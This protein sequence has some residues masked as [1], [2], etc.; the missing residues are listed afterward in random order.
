MH[1]TEIE[2]AYAA[3]QLSGFS[4]FYRLLA[5]PDWFMPVMTDEQ[6]RP[7]SATLTDPNGK[8]FVQ[9]LAEETELQFAQIKAPG[10]RLLAGLEDEV[11]YVLLNVNNER[12]L[13]FT[14]EQ[15]NELRLVAQV[16][17]VDSLLGK[18]QAGTIEQKEVELLREHKFMAVL[19]ADNT[20]GLAPESVLE[21]A[22]TMF[23]YNEA[24]Q[25]YLDWYAA[26][27]YSGD[28]QV[29]QIAGKHFFNAAVEVDNSG[30]VVNGLS[31]DAQRI[32]LPEHY[33]LLA[34][35]E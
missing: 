4:L 30:L 13:R 17:M 34:G 19:V 8:Q 27:G 29:A 31:D 23:S 20:I 21:G 35:E 11:D 3:G 1:P 26:Q 10:Y 5:Y 24:V 7:T 6:N 32:L 9:L 15:Y 25:E 12:G 33:R 14:P 28:P 16:A 22:L 18:A 2:A